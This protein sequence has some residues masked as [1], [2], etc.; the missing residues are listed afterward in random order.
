MQPAEF[1]A[2]LHSTLA[3]RKLTRSERQ[4][5]QAAIAASAPSP[6]HLAVLRS[7]VFALATAQA[8]DAQAR[9]LL[10]WCEDVLKL[11]LPAT[12]PANRVA[13]AHFSPGLAC[14]NRIT[15]LI[16]ATR[17]SLDVCVFTVTDD[18]IARAMLE[19][20]ARGV[21]VRLLSDNEKSQDLGSDILRLA[22]AG[23]QVV[24]DRTPKHMHH[25]FA[26][27]DQRLLLTGSY[28]WTRAAADENEENLIVS[29]DPKLIAPFT[30][31]FEKL[32]R[33]LSPR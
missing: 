13:E 24:I 33:M 3:D 26:L 23:I 19:A 22:Q 30:A 29:D 18:R 21:K 10:A 17:K 31:E 7:R 12:A 14:V 8:S 6:E 5:L 20:H 28:N 4:A 2:A 16:A 9:E 25:K 32:W 15:Q 11:L 27:F 1:D